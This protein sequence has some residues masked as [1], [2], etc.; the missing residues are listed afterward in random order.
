MD[1]RENFR[2]PSYLG[3][4]T[5]FA[6]VPRENKRVFPGEF[7]TVT[8]WLGTVKVQVTWKS[9]LFPAQKRCILLNSGGF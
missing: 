9:R 1:Q 7:P 3:E 4:K 5:T 8:C 2:E 6:G